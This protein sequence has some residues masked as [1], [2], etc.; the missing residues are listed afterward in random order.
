MARYIIGRRSLPIE[1]R[2]SKHFDP[3][4]DEPPSTSSAS[5]PRVLHDTRPP[6]RVSRFRATTLLLGT[7]CCRTPA[8][9]LYLV[10]RCP[11]LP[12]VSR[13]AGKIST[14]ELLCVSH[15]Q[16]R[17]CGHP[18]RPMVDAIVFSR[19]VLHGRVWWLFRWRAR[20]VLYTPLWTDASPASHFNVWPRQ[21]HHHP[22]APTFRRAVPHHSATWHVPPA[23]LICLMLTSAA[24]V[25]S[26]TN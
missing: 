14:T 2:D 3:P 23:L 13:A 4:P 10:S 22:R 8:S 20:C 5:S 17:K 11:P 9:F 12:R 25:P 24:D 16:T 1:L 7:S 21:Q 15:P 18:R 6:T 26:F 19:V